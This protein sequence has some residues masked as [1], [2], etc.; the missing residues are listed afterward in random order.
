MPSLKREAETEVESAKRFPRPPIRGSRR[1]RAASLA[2]TGAQLVAQTRA[3]AVAEIT[4]P[5]NVIVLQTA[6][7]SRKTLAPSSA[8]A[9][10]KCVFDVVDGIDVAADRVAVVF[11]PGARARQSCAPLLPPPLKKA[12]I[13][14]DF[15]DVRGDVT[16][17][18]ADGQHGLAEAQVVVKT[19][20]G[21]AV[22]VSPATSETSNELLKT[23]SRG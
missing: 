17:A 19:A 7:A 6:V 8:P 3:D 21:F 10:G 4:G 18:R 15:V 14:R 5:G 22:N 9:M 11:G 20:R 23:I 16:A 2:S 12:D 13:D 1:S